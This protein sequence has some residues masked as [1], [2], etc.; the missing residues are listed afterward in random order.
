MYFDKILRIWVLDPIDYFLL[1]ACVGSALSIQLKKYL[2]EQ[3]AERRRNRTDRRAMKRLAKS[4]VKQSRLYNNATPQK[5]S[6]HAKEQQRLRRIQS[7]ALGQ[8]RGG[9][10]LGEVDLTH[11][12]V[13]SAAEV[14][15][16]VITKLVFST[17]C[18][19]II[20]FTE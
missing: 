2:S 14:I 5:M 9:Q 6:S 16:D 7:V 11:D 1:S 18:T 19:F 20:K 8:H 10:F 3:E 15:K 4:I 13:I 12:K 17:N